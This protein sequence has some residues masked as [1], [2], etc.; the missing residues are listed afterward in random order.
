MTQ[1]HNILYV[2]SHPIQYQAPLLRLISQS[3]DISV[4]TLFYWSKE[5]DARFDEGFGQKVVWDVPLLSGYESHYLSDLA[6]SANLFQKLRALWKIIDVN[7]YTIVW[8][9][10]YRD[11]FTC[12]AILV[13]KIKGLTVFVRGESMYFAKEKPDLKRKLFFKI[14]DKFVDCYLVIGTP[15]K[16]FY[17]N[18]GIASN[19]IFL[20]P[21]TV[22]NQFFREKFLESKNKIATL[23][24]A[25]QLEKSRPII[26]YAS[27]FIIRKYP[28]DVLNA[29][30]MMCKNLNAPKPY[31]LYI[32][33]GE[34][35]DDVKKQAAIDPEHI[36]FLGFKN[37][38]ELPDYF[39]L[40]DILILPSLRENWGLII[41]EA[42]SAECAIVV[43]DQVGCATD[44]VKPGVNGFIFPA[45]DVKK[46]SDYLKTLV[47]DHAL[48]EKMKINS[49]EIISHWGLP[50]TVEG[51]RAA[52][53][54]A[55]HI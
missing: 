15:N 17:L 33:T 19:K 6:K 9:H 44:L 45:R 54:F 5:S 30:L 10:G 50:E 20:C 16:N 46:L 2:I 49:N 31:L 53:K 35:F 24:Q 3:S 38:S 13:A 28:I 55:L 12:A 14:L 21:Y 48:C 26:L 25:L 39:V 4:T 43:S 42:M 51:L 8:V 23:K 37:Q 41:N 27:K 40:A 1:K 34:T 18:N 32:G 11:I 36:R 47:T 52:C 22:D 7:K 29:Y